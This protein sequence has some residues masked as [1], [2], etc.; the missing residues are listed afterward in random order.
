MRS[1]LRRPRRR[2]PGFLV[3]ALGLLSP[4]MPALAGELRAGAAAR[5]ESLAALEASGDQLS[6]G[7]VEPAASAGK[8]ALSPAGA[9]TGPEGY[10]FSGLAKAPVVAVTAAPRT[11]LSVTF[12][13][14]ALQGPGPEIAL[15][16]VTH[17]GGSQLATD[18]AGRLVLRLGAAATVNADQAPGAY[19]GVARVIVNY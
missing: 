19:L 4:A 7:A 9:L 6:F 17:D 14:A 16:E 15:T 12:V 1:E 3:L 18:A 8:V 11:A 13:S 5:I 2:L 10:G